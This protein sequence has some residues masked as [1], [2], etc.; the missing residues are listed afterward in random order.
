MWKPDI[1]IYHGNCDDGFGAAWAIWRRWPDVEFVPGVYGKPLPDVT[2]KHV[3]FVDFSAKRPEIDA[4]AQVAKSIVVIDHH[5]TAEADLEPFAVTL[6]GSARLS[7]EDIGSMFEDRAEL[8]MPPVI[9]WFDMAQSGAVMAYEFAHGVE[10][11]PPPTMLAYIQDRD[12]W[13]FA[14]GD[15]TKQFSAALRTYPMDFETWDRIAENPERLVEEG[16]IVLRAHLA[17]IAKFVADAYEDDVAG[18][19]VPVV[20]VPYH[21]ASDTAHA[22]LANYPK[23]P[24]TACWFRR[25]DGMIQW[26]LRSEDHRLDVSEIAKQL[27]G[28]GHRN[29]AG[30]QYPAGD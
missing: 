1:C 2:G 29:A 19:I 21:Y 11:V 8:G 12:L 3:L 22:L 7:P 5:K 17:N 6:C 18:H 23:A 27:G 10:H 30:F 28:G 15:R 16:K 25:G 4:M 13:R 9:A 20:N 24:F 14:L 26:S